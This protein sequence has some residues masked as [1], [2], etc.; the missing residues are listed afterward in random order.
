[1]RWDSERGGYVETCHRCGIKFSVK[2]ERDQAERF[3]YCRDCRS[4]AVLL[5]WIEPWE[6]MR[7]AA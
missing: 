1:M 6:E 3:L 2:P 5:G 4:E 7:G